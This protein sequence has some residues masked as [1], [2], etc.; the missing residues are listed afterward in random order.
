M[1]QIRP[2]GLLGVAWFVAARLVARA[3]ARWVPGVRGGAP[4]L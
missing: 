2:A 4:L 3:S 1:A